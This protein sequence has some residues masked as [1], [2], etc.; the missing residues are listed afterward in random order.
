MQ[1]DGATE[2]L[3]QYNTDS[4]QSSQQNVP[5][6]TV[7]VL[8]VGGGI[9]GLSTGLLLQ[10]A[11]KSCVI[12]DSYEIGYGTTSGTTAHI[13]TLLDTSYNQI[14]S[15]FGEDNAQLVAA[16][17]REALDMIRKNVEELRIDCNY[18]EQPGFVFSQT[19]E[20]TKELEKILEASRKAGIE[21]AYSDTIPVPLPFEKAVKATQ[22]A[23]FHPLRYLHALA[24][25]FSERGG[26]LLQN[27]HYNDS[28]SGDV[29]EASTS[30]GAIKAK[31]LL[32]ATHIPP[33]INLLSLRCAPYR[34]Y[35]IAVKL[36]GNNYPDGLCYDMYDP[37]H[38]YRT[39][40]INGE[41]FLIAGGEDHKTG[42]QDNTEASFLKLEAYLKNHYDIEKTAFKWS[43]QFYEPADGLPYIGKMPGEADN[44]F[45]ASGFSGNGMTYSTLSS[46]VISSLILQGTSPYEKL[47]NPS[48]IKPV[49][50]FANFVK[51]N[52]DVAKEFVSGRFS[53]SSIEGVS[54]L[55]KG[56]A[57]VVKYEGKKIGLYKDEQGNLH[58]VNPVCTHAKCIVSWN[59]A[60]HTWDCPCHGGRFSPEGKVLTGPP[61]VDLERI[62]LEK[63]IENA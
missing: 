33:G 52:A 12:I 10:R 5:A 42:H 35:A 37:Y 3:W 20:Q 27:C 56:E 39:E 24:R 31:N 59:T 34:S 46:I 49:A 29:I 55:A 41:K 32:Y 11:G 21:I 4:Y 7:D 6:E 63:I 9:T 38:Y 47:F 26:M 57:R 40:E 1:R 2:S 18:S 23:Q 25:A 50:G 62:D 51:E 36:A 19:P 14:E 13:N 17:A 44:Y 60:E 22:Q 58:A 30:L 28:K 45:V 48:R 54:E 53:A 15:D 43:S 8:I 61:T 16:G